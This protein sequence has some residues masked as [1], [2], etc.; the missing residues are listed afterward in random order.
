MLLALA[1]ATWTTLLCSQTTFLD[2]FESYNVGEYLG[3][4]SPDWTTWSGTTGGM[5]DVQI[6]AA[7]AHSGTKSIYFSSTDSSG[8]PQDVVLPFGAEYDNGVFTFEMWMKVEAGKGGYF[9]FQADDIVAQSWA[10][11]VLFLETGAVDVQSQ[12]AQVMSGAYPTDTWFKVNWNINLSTNNWQ[13]L[14]NDIP[15]GSFANSDNRIASLDL[16]PVNSQ[17]N[18]LSG[19]YVDDVSYTHTPPAPPIGVTAVPGETFS[20][21]PNP[22][23]D[24]VVLTFEAGSEAEV[25]VTDVTGRIVGNP[26]LPAGS[27][28]MRIDV[29]QFSSGLYTVQV[30]SNGNIEAR[31]LIMR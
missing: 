5:E 31:K 9:N 28:Q 27:K 4:V 12:Q 30:R 2:D 11:D 1:T 21:T 26:K 18:N 22:A 19:F 17:G 10:V 29:G 16:Y 24:W 25:M 7:D 6:T 20:M 3:A 8:G 14:I 23:S 13:L 15:L